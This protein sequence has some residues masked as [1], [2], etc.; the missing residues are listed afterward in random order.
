MNSLQDGTYANMID[1]MVKLSSG[2]LQ[3]QNPE[4][5]E[6]RSI[7]NAFIPSDQLLSQLKETRKITSVSKRLETFAL[8]SS[9]L[10]TRGGAVVG[11][12]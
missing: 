12:E 1:M 10:N 8:L 4:Y 11:F 9:G 6:D 5:R 7:N 2:Y 3:V